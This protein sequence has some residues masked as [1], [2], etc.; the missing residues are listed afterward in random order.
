[1]LKENSKELSVGI[2][3][4]DDQ[5]QALLDTLN[6]LIQALNLGKP[7]EEIDELIQSLEEGVVNHLNTEEELMVKYNYPE[8]PIHK[9]HHE[10]LLKRF[11]SFKKEYE[12]KG[13]STNLALQIERRIGDW[14]K[15]H[16]AFSDKPMSAFIKD[17]KKSLKH[18]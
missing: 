1:M 6:Q 15:D 2:D 5:H 10:T 4:I 3:K 11:E 12:A 18:S 13:A 14:M 16:I 7:A 8:Y 9:G 17:K